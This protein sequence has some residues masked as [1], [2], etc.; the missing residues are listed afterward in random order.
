VYAQFER[1]RNQWLAQELAVLS[2]E[3]RDTL[4]RAASIL[5]KVARA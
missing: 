1:A 3:E 5:Q 4:E 2:R